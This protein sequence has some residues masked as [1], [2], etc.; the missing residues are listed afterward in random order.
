MASR[1]WLLSVPASLR[2]SRKLKPRTISVVSQTAP[3][4]A[5]KKIYDAGF[6]VYQHLY[7]SLKGDFR[8][9]QTTIAALIT[10]N[11]PDAA[12]LLL[13]VEF[14]RAMTTGCSMIKIFGRCLAVVR[15]EV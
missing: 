4:A 13:H 2:T 3:K 11:R 7:Q 15:N 12:V 9:C 1:S 8:D 10:I 5:A 14:C 6:P